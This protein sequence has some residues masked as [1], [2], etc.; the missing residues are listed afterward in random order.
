MP[1]DAVNVFL[2][3]APTNDVIYFNFPSR[4]SPAFLELCRSSRINTTRYLGKYSA[5]QHSCLFAC[6]FLMPRW[7]AAEAVS[8]CSPVERPRVF[9]SVTGVGYYPPHPTQLYDESCAQ[10]NNNLF[11]F[12]IT[13]KC[14]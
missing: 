14:W 12:L 7:C 2:S 11:S 10:V 8:R 13:K 5:M 6:F 1:I 9:V 4:W 3:L